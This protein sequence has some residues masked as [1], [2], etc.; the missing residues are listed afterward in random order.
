[1][2]RKSIEKMIVE[3]MDDIRLQSLGVAA[4]GVWVMLMKLVRDLGVDGRLTFGMGRAP[5]LADIAR[6]RFDMTETE[7]KTHLETQ[8]KT[9]LILWNAE[10][11]TLGY[12]METHLDR[13][14]IANREN[15]RKGGRPRKNA[16]TEKN[17][18]RQRHV[19]PMAIAGGKAMTDSKTQTG[20]GFSPAIAK[21]DIN[22]SIAKAKQEPNAS[23]VDALFNVLGPA[24]F[25][26]AEFDPARN[27]SGWGIARQWAA[28]GLAK[29]L[30]SEAVV[31]LVT[32]EIARVLEACKKRG[33][34]PTHL[35]YFKNPIA[36][37]IAVAEPA[38]SVADHVIDAA[39]QDAM[40]AWM[41]K[42]DLN[43]P[44][45]KREEIAAR[46]AA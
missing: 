38:R 30:S 36:V 17:D 19:P 5:H 18:P 33:K 10:T 13:R 15:G 37:V 29:G 31:D 21:A 28:D 44:Q 35:G 8:S 23:E 24:A 16:L 40:N 42:G 27:M 3:G 11:G 7:L 32:S 9:E 14:T 26:A 12:P 45:P 1:M 6:L 22:L 2:A 20:N 34:L 25:E 46:I 43:V 4:I 41:R 39:F